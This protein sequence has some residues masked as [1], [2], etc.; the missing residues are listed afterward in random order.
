MER[1]ATNAELFG[2]GRHVAVCRSKPKSHIQV[3]R[4]E[5]KQLLMQCQSLRTNRFAELARGQD[6]DALKFLECK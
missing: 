2:S 6:V 1:A 4:P 5:R 3:A